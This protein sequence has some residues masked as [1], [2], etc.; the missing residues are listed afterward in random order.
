MNTVNVLEFIFLEH[1]EIVLRWHTQN[2]V[3]SQYRVDTVDKTGMCRGCATSILFL[4]WLTQNHLNGL[5]EYISVYW[6]YQR[7]TV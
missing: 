4:R 3:Y 7:G 5:R 6:Q 1:L 2:H